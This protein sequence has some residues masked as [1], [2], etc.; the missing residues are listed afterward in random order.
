MK[1]LKDRMRFLEAH[2]GDPVIARAIL[3][4]PP[5]LSSLAASNFW[6][7]VIVQFSFLRISPLLFRQRKMDAWYPI[8]LGGRANKKPR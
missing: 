6:I 3:T 8:N 1:D 7:R 4:A 5:F 2:G